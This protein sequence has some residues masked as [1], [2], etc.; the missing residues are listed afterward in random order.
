[1]LTDSRFAWPTVRM[2]LQNSTAWI[3]CYFKEGCLK[4]CLEEGS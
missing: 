1:M 2:A 3:S 4:L